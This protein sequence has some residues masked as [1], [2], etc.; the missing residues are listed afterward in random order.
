MTSKKMGVILPFKGQANGETVSSN[1]S[2]TAASGQGTGKRSVAREES[3]AEINPETDD[4]E[5][6]REYLK[7]EAKTNENIF[8]NVYEALTGPVEIIY[9]A[10]QLMETHVKGAQPESYDEKFVK[11]VNSIKQ[12]CFRMTKLINNLADLSR[13]AANKYELDVCDINIVEAAE[14]IV[15]GAADIVRDKDIEIIFDTNV[16]EKTISCDIDKIKKV[17]LNLLSNAVKC[18]NPGSRIKAT[19]AASDVSV[20]IRVEY[21]SGSDKSIVDVPACL[22]DGCRD[23]NQSENAYN[24]ELELSKSIIELHGGS[25]LK[26]SIEGRDCV[27]TVILPCKNNESIYYLYST[28]NGGDYDNLMTQINIEFSDQV[29]SGWN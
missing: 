27:F 8:L 24:I 18:S 4:R 29:Y 28:E 12:N 26:E 25:L 17:I 21:C 10:S 20:E 16:E 7:E 11:S 6:L 14:R 22:P 2:L 9:G 5:K 1:V 13:I 15:L 23:E 19:V 3:S